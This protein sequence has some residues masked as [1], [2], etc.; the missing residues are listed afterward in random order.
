MQNTNI[1][2]LIKTFSKVSSKKYLLGHL[3]FHKTYLKVEFKKYIV[4]FSK[5]TNTD[6]VVG[7]GRDM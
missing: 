5:L 2:K 3:R 4:V 7:Y 1:I 6:Y